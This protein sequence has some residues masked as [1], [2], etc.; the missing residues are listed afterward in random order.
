MKEVCKKCGYLTGA[1]A[2]RYKCYCGSC[3]AKKR[4]EA[5]KDKKRKKKM[6]IEFK[7]NFETM[8]HDPHDYSYAQV[9]L[10]PRAYHKRN[11]E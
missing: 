2:P 9:V 1:K 7:P 8:L 3:P 11:D 4:D 6:K 10:N 5:A